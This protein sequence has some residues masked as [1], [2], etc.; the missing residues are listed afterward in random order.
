[1]TTPCDSGALLQ[2][3]LSCTVI[4]PTKAAADQELRYRCPIPGCNYRG[5]KT[6]HASD[7]LKHLL[8]PKCDLQQHIALLRDRVVIFEAISGGPVLHSR[9][10][11]E[12]G[13]DFFQSD[14]AGRKTWH[15]YM[16]VKLCSACFI[17]SSQT[18]QN[19]TRGCV[20]QT[21]GPCD[22]CGAPAVQACSTCPLTMCSLHCYQGASLGEAHCKEGMY[23]VV[24]PKCN[25]NA[26]RKA[27]S[28]IHNNMLNLGYV[29]QEVITASQHCVHAYVRGPTVKPEQHQ[30]KRPKTTPA[31]AHNNQAAMGQWNPMLL[32]TQATDEVPGTSEMQASQL[33]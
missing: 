7:C 8:E 20:I 1:M 31:V 15:A 27:A 3:H 5:A 2:P 26:A 29:I 13:F 14:D 23:Y 32:S 25:P 24:C 19:D 28:W 30:Q 9:R 6:T 12:A 33:A 16:K 4:R 10:A 11:I 17:R 21:G 18:C 22:L